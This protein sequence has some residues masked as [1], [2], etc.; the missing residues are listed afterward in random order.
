MI[1]LSGNLRQ[2][3]E[4]ITAENVKLKDRIL[5]YQ[6]ELK[7]LKNSNKRLEE[8]NASKKVDYESAIAEKDAIIKE[9]KNKIAHMA[10]I[11][12]HDGTNTGTPTSATPINKKKAIPNSRRGS[13]KKKGGQP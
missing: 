7:S 12:D 9:L 3:F 10:A 1:K 4:K 8:S 13:N 2:D 6:E 5:G 11:A